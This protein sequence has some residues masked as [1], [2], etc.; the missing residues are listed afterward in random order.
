MKACVRALLDGLPKLYLAPHWQDESK[1][2]LLSAENVI[3][4]GYQPSPYNLD[5]LLPS[6]IMTRRGPSI[7]KNLRIHSP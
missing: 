2:V 1:M 7:S 4:F 6:G 3:G 5:I